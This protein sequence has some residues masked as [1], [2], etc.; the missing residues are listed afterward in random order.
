MQKIIAS[1]LVQKKE[2]ALPG[3]GSF[4]INTKPAGLDIA[5]K[6]IFPP[7]DEIVFNENEVHLQNELITY[8]SVQQ[9]IDQLYAAGNISNWCRHA[10][11]KLDAGEKIYFDSIGTLQKNAGGNIFLQRRK[12][13]QFYQPVSAE[14][15][16]HKNEEHSVLV[17][18]RETTSV[19]MN[20]FFREEDVIEKRAWWKIWAIIMFSI[21]LLI[22]I[23]HFSNHSFS[24]SGVG[25]QINLTPEVPPVSHNEFK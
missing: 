21:S 19:V 24:T 5:N 8:I 9:N 2:C 1:Y 18:D 7:T 12:A 23:I 17:G 15:I 20:E 14:R 10:K 25:N 13:I 22:L 16:I 4:K 11:D 6:Q 3:I